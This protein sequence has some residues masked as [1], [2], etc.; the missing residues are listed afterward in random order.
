MCSSIWLGLLPLALL[1]IFANV[2]RTEGVET[3]LREQAAAAL[4]SASP[5]LIDKPVV[6]VS[7]R[8]ASI[9]GT[10]FTADAQKTIVSMVD[11]IFGVR[12][13]NTSVEPLAVQKPYGFSATREG[14]QIVLKGFSPLPSVR[15]KLIDAARSAFPGATIVDQMAFAA[16]APQDFGTV[17]AYGMGLVSKL[18]KAS[19]ALSDQALSVAGEAANSADYQ[20]AM[21][22]LKQTPAG[23]SIAKADIL[24]PEMKPYGWNAVFDGKI[25]TLS[26]AAPTIEARDAIMAK[27]TALF[28]GAPA[29][30]LDIARGAPA[31]D[32]SGAVS[33]ALT[34]LSHL[35]TGK[36]SFVDGVLSIS[37]DGKPNVS[38]S[39]IEADA[40]TGLPQGF[41][42]GKLEIVDGVISPYGFTAAKENGNLTLAGHVPDDKTRAELLDLIRRKFFDT[43]V[44]DKLAIGKGAPQGF[45]AAASALLGGLSRLASG[46]ASLSGEA[47]DFKGEALYEKAIGQILASLKSGLPPGF[48]QPQAALAV[49]NAGPQLEASAC[50]PL[51]EGVLSKGKILFET[52]STR[53][54]ADSAAVLDNLVAVANK[55][56]AAKLEIGGHTDSVGSEDS[57]R[58]LSKRRAEAVVGYLTEAGI[59]EARLTAEGYGES[60]PIAS[61]DTDEGRAQNRRIEFQVR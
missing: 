38:A 27:A 56:A 36:A 42:I 37:G 55:C 5:D 39:G 15:A 61:N 40:K 33:F 45:G 8:D 46:T 48:S 19:F 43:K 26:G 21:A 34:E 44:D 57:N 32:F 60:K 41:R 2:F 4:A 25:V 10:A 49:Q 6:T 11:S 52:G 47:A 50:Q 7:G 31:G 13:V 1:W 14:D 12:L 20:A 9:G 28:G 35:A 29:G 22:A 30:S 23:T 51:F 58:A 3:G 16:G 18:S 17:A 59:D 54:D 53:I 24:P